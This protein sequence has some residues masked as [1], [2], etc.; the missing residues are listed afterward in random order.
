MRAVQLLENE[1]SIRL[2]F[3]HLVH[4]TYR[5]TALAADDK[6]RVSKRKERRFK[7]DWNHQY[8][9]KPLLPF[10]S[11]RHATL[12]S[13]HISEHVKTSPRH[14]AELPV[15]LAPLTSLRRLRVDGVT[16]STDFLPPLFAMSLDTLD[17]S[18]S[19]LLCYYKGAHPPPSI[20]SVA[21]CALLRSCRILRLPRHAGIASWQPVLEALVTE[22]TE[23]SRLQEL[24]LRDTLTPTVIQR[25]VTLPPQC[26]LTVYP[27]AN[28]V[29]PNVFLSQAAASPHFTDM[30]RQLR[31][32]LSC[33]KWNEQRHMQPFVSFVT[34][35]HARI[36]SL[37]LIS[38]PQLPEVISS[39]LAV[40]SH[41]TQ[42]RSLDMGVLTGHTKVLQG[43]D[44]QVQWA[45]QRRFDHL[46]TLNL[47]RG[48]DQQEMIDL[49]S[50]CPALRSCS[51]NLPNLVTLLNVLASCCPLLSRLQLR[52]VAS[53]ELTGVTMSSQIP[54]TPPPP[55]P[56]RSLQQLD[57]LCHIS[58]VGPPSLHALQPYL[59]DSPLRR[60]SL[61]VVDANS[62]VTA[63][64]REQHQAAVT[65]L[66][67][68]LPTLEKVKVAWGGSALM[69]AQRVNPTA[70]DDE[71]RSE[72]ADNQRQQQQQ[73]QQA[74]HR[75][76]ADSSSLPGLSS[77]RFEHP[78]S[79]LVSLEL[80][81]SLYQPPIHHIGALLT[82]CPAVTHIRLIIN[83]DDLH[84]PTLSP[85]LTFLHY[86]AH[87]GLHCPLIEQINFVAVDVRRDVQPEEQQVLDEQAVR[88]VV[89]AYDM[90]AQAFGHLW[91]VRELRAGCEVLSEESV[92]YVRQ[93][94]LINVRDTVVLAWAGS[95]QH[96]C[97]S[98]WATGDTYDARDWEP[99]E[100]ERQ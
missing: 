39:A 44:Q 90:P 67:A 29:A 20:A 3:P 94:W 10:L 16:L 66:L 72:E 50:S 49:L 77:T 62:L 93:K 12:R 54:P 84:N 34:A 52:E 31:L 23:S 24:S 37:Q 26:A 78:P 87:I 96:Y 32:S 60:L 85:L 43:H 98:N 41:C 7:D 55:T 11:T 53:S 86:L 92:E 57:L 97:E 83:N 100:L 64:H 18:N 70:I 1:R 22:R 47:A 33:H 91:R 80:V 48:F 17:L 8:Y 79:A 42:L 25:L 46:Q 5:H 9:M 75:P 99:A 81:V 30:P 74:A 6:D 95:W 28:D 88:E 2:L 82:H 56:F 76:P 4:F 21:D 38:L 65:A 13:L 40:V 36:R 69:A 35:H 63:Q 68:A 61:V 27:V 71:D 51:L 45:E 19:L 15:L 59:V 89:D 58:P 14:L 73:Q